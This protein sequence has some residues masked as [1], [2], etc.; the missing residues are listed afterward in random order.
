MYDNQILKPEQPQMSNSFLTFAAID[1]KSKLAF[2]CWLILLVLGLSGRE[3]E[4]SRT[5]F[6]Y[7]A[8]PRFT[9]PGLFWVDVGMGFADGSM[10]AI[11]DFNGDR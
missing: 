11:G 7:A 10:A 2:C 3:Q 1:F 6:A 4:G 9:T 5:L 8:T